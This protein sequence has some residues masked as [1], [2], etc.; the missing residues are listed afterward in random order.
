[1]AAATV[2]DVCGAVIEDVSYGP[3]EVEGKLCVGTITQKSDIG[4][5]CAKC[6]RKEYY[7]VARQLFETMQVKRPKKEG[8]E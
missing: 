4:D 7:A 5:V 1:M 8:K 3:L 2:C 6:L